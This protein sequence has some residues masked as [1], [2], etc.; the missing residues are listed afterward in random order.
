MRIAT[1]ILAGGLLFASSLSEV[2]AGSAL[3]S[4]PE[5]IIALQAFLKQQQPVGGYIVIGDM[6]FKVSDFSTKA[7]SSGRKWTDGVFVYAFE[8]NLDAAKKAAFVQACNQW[9]VNTPITCKERTTETNYAMVRNHDGGNK[10]ICGG[11]NTSCSS[12]GMTGGEQPIW[13][14]SGQWSSQRTLVHEIGHA[15]G[16]VHEHARPDQDQYIYI[17]YGNVSPG[18]ESQFQ[19]VPGTALLSAYDYLSI[20]HYSNCA[21][22]VNPGCTTTTPDLQ[23]IVPRACHIDIVGGNDITELDREGIR[24]SYAPGLQSLL[25]R[26]SRPQCGQYEFTPQQVQACGANCASASQV[27]FKKVDTLYK[28]WC[29]FTPIQFPETWCVP[30]NKTYIRH[31]WDTDTASCGFFQN[32]H[33]LWVECGCP[34]RRLNALCTDTSKFSSET[35][36]KKVGEFPVWRNG[37]L[38]LFNQIM[39]QLKQDGLISDAVV[40]SLGAF[41][42]KNYMDPLFETKFMKVRAGVYSYAHW[43]RSIVPGYE[44]SLDMFRKIA[45][46]RKLRVPAEG[47]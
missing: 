16:L 47:T 18:S 37:R 26:D 21:Y 33:E 32:R 27:E 4:D 23:T 45:L 44:L 29:G 9:T 5:D 43:K 7:A 24:N 12:I 17:R 13:V 25:V 40:K 15:L 8:A 42:Q 11:F 14:Y 38:I 6:L 39:E 31:W 28:N 30:I 1:A 34:V 35:I 41:Y 19:P 36:Q 10:S 46:Y 3:S 20:M 22:A 2:R